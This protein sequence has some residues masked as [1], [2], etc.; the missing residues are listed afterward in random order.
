MAEK[1]VV[2]KKSFL[3]S[4]QVLYISPSLFI[5]CFTEVPRFLGMDER[6]KADRYKKSY[7]AG[8]T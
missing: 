2:T 4:A 5:K 6:H 1:C 3:F 7:L 8:G